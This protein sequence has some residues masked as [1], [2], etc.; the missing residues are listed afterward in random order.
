MKRS[1]C[2]CGVEKEEI[3]ESTTNLAIAVAP[4]MLAVV[5]TERIDAAKLERAFGRP[6]QKI[7]VIIKFGFSLAG[8]LGTNQSSL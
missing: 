7:G 1:N 2:E 6:G 4:L 8:E 3:H 5:S